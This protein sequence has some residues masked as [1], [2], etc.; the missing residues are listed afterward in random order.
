MERTEQWIGGCCCSVC[1][2]GDPP[3]V[4]SSQA[5]HNC[6][7]VERVALLEIWPFV[8]SPE[9]NNHVADMVDRANTRAMMRMINKTLSA[10]T[11]KKACTVRTALAKNDETYVSIVKDLL[12]TK[13][14]SQD[15]LDVCLTQASIDMTSKR[16]VMNIF[17][18]LYYMIDVITCKSTLIIQE[19]SV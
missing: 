1:G 9:C 14:G 15:V 3:A 10:S 4:G 8:K 2:G 5:A 16:C 17:K 19:T 13:L 6:A 18:I 12:P 7:H 11:R